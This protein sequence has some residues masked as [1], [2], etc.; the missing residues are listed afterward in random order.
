MSYLPCFKHYLNAGL[1]EIETANKLQ[2]FFRLLY[3]L[4]GGIRIK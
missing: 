3:H 1:I 4:N 2:T